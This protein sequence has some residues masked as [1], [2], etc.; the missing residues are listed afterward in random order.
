MQEL[1]HVGYEDTVVKYKDRDVRG[2]PEYRRLITPM[3]AVRGF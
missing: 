2:V 3:V 1:P